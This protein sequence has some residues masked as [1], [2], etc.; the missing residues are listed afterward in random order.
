MFQPQALITMPWSAYYIPASIPYQ[1]PW[2]VVTNGGI[3][4]ARGLLAQPDQLGALWSSQ[5][6]WPGKD[7]LFLT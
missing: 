5:G 6:P 3:T 2:A 7:R 1:N 4:N